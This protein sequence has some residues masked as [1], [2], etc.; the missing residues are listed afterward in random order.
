[1]QFW[2]SMA[3]VLLCCTMIASSSRAHE[4]RRAEPSAPAEASATVPLY[5]NLGNLTYPVT[6]LSP[7]AQRYFDQGLRLTYAFNHAEALR[8]FREAQWQDPNC[9]MCYWGEAFVLGPNINA[10]M[11]ETAGSPAVAAI[12]QAKA[13]APRVS[14][15]EQTLINALVTRYTDA[16][17]T[18]R[19]ALD[20]AYAEAMAEATRRFPDDT[21]IAVL[22]IDAIMN[23]SPWDYW[24]A[25]GKT[26]KGQIGDAI[27]IAEH[28]LARH[29]DHPG[30]IHLYIHLTEAS[31]APERA[32]PYA[33]RLA[34]L[35]PGAGHLVHMGSHTFFRV[36]RYQDSAEANK[37][38]VKADEAYLARVQDAGLYAYG[39]YPHNIHF[40]LV[41]AQMMGDSKTTLEYA[42]R[43]DGKIPDAM[44][45][46]VGWVQAIKTAPYFA[47]AQF[48]TPE[49]ILAL[50]DP[51]DKFPFVKAMWHYARGVGLAAQGH[52]ELAQQEAA[53][54]AEITQRADF[55]FLLAWTVPAPDLLRLARHVV[56]GRIAQ[57]Q[58]DPARA[59]KEFQVAVSIQDTLAYM[60]PPYWYYPVRQSLGAALLEAG[61][62]A[63]AEQVFT[64]SLAQFPHNGWAL[65]GLMKAQQAQ[66]NEAAA[67]ETEKRL[68]QTWA[69]DPAM[70]TLKRL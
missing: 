45:E 64:Q 5:D 40:V 33:N 51:G 58:G 4:V 30:A 54:I 3:A 67:Q 24:E 23:L 27:R 18:E 22:A 32:E 48:S 34:A 49:T 65:Y 69:G 12:T 11:D 47:H 52:I 26:P 46:K 25:D 14:A 8:A 20:R 10:P 7:L 35:M 31:A 62:P 13:L 56:E 36:G 59:I 1:M 66:N 60:E 15:R 29:P 2:T 17:K 43:L 44:A 28:V 16:P 39:Y 50:P 9:A 37:A 41:S 68:K 38:A 63:E 42:Q 6:T 70:L 53:H 55:S 19:A 61:K 21:E 57:A